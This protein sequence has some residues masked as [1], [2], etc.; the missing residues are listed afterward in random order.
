[1]SAGSLQAMAPDLRWL[2]VNGDFGAM[3]QND[4]AKVQRMMTALFGASHGE[5]TSNLSK[6][7][8]VINAGGA[9]APSFQALYQALHPEDAAQGFTRL[10]S[11][12]GTQAA[13]EMNLA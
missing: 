8:S 5:I 3:N 11:I 4:P 2:T 6:A 7:H 12:V 10:K 9:E 13:A 1:L